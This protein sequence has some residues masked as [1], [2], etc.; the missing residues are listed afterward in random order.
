MTGNTHTEDARRRISEARKG[1]DTFVKG[2][3][4]Y[5]NGIESKYFKKDTQPEGWKRGSIRDESHSNKGKKWYTDGKDVKM[6]HEGE[7]PE[8]WKIGRSAIVKK[9]SGHSGGITDEHKK[10]I[11]LSRVGKKW[12]NNG[13][14]SRLFFEGEQ[15]KDWILGNGYRNNSIFL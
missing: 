12:Y 4:V 11:A 1:K 14:T 15:W 13:V 8:G 3:L 10:N 5:N 6:F 7:A 9:K 2:K